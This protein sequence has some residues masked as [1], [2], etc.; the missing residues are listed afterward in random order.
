METP[1]GTTTMMMD[2]SSVDLASL[3]R[4]HHHGLCYEEPTKRT[5]AVCGN[6]DAEQHVACVTDKCQYRICGGCVLRFLGKQD[7]RPVPVLDEAE[8]R[9]MLSIVHAHGLEWAD[10]RTNGDYG[11]EGSYACDMCN[12]SGEGYSYHCAECGFDLCEICAARMWGQYRPP[13]N[14]ELRPSVEERKFMPILKSRGTCSVCTVKMAVVFP[15][16]WYRCNMCVGVNICSECFAHRKDKELH[17][18]H[19]TMTSMPKLFQMWIASKSE[20]T[21]TIRSLTTRTTPLTPEAMAN[22]NEFTRGVF[23][24]CGAE[25]DIDNPHNPRGHPDELMNHEC[26]VVLPLLQQQ[27]G[28]RVP[29]SDLQKLVCPICTKVAKV[30]TSIVSPTCC[31]VFCLDCAIKHTKTSKLCPADGKPLKLTSCL[32]TDSLIDFFETM[33]C[34]CL[35]DGCEMNV[36]VVQ[37]AEHALSCDHRRL[38]ACP[39]RPAGCRYVGIDTD[40]QNHMN[41]D[42]EGSSHFDPRACIFSRTLAFIRSNEMSKGVM[43]QDIKSLAK[44]LSALEQQLAL[45]TQERDFCYAASVFVEEEDEPVI[46][47]TS[48]SSGPSG[49]DAFSTHAMKIR[50]I[51]EGYAYDSSAPKYTWN[52][53]TMGKDVILSDDKLTVRSR[54]P[55]RTLANHPLTKGTHYWEV[56]ID[57]HPGLGNVCVGLCQ[58]PVDKEGKSTLKY[59]QHLGLD[60][61][62]WAWI[63]SGTIR[64]KNKHF[65]HAEASLRYEKGHYLGFLFIYEKGEVHLYKNRVHVYKITE[66]TKQVHDPK[67]K[68]KIT[69]VYYPA[70]S[71]AYTYHSVT[72]KPNAPQQAPPDKKVSN[73]V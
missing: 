35:N 46:K 39:L 41:Q 32:I 4:M 29:E 10:L 33:T 73:A 1:E 16:G 18:A 42:V 71:T 70:V 31:H 22:L 23:C 9:A 30:R 45:I 3:A 37:Y 36:P 52:P 20:K 12:R 65:E 38:M 26:D 69:P 13:D 60:D 8:K 63:S 50:E 27:N 2:W 68:R 72:L 53:E 17:P 25:F 19:H 21:E 57:T 61:Y 43:M 6:V 66:I 55:Q 28:E 34:P 24:V 54:T 59:D 64:N 49:M 56:R 62:S 7:T 11:E 5:C 58:I 44:Q 14:D 40:V 47:K 67:S 48:D 51:E 15:N